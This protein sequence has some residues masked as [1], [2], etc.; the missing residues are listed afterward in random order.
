M[1][2]DELKNWI[3]HNILKDEINHLFRYFAALSVTQLKDYPENLNE[4]IKDYK[5]DW[6]KLILAG[7]VFAQ[8]TDEISND[9]ALLIAHSGLLYSNKKI[10]QKAA[11]EILSQ[12]QNQRTIQ[13]WN[14]LHIKNKKQIETIGTLSALASFK[15]KMS[16]E[17]ITENNFIIHANVFQKKLWE[18]LKNAQ[19]V[20]VSAPTASGKTFIILHWILSL[21]KSKKSNLMVYL[22]PTRA[23]VGEIERQFLTYSKAYHLPEL[24]ISSLP[25]SKFGNGTCPTILVLTQERLHVFLNATGSDV[26]IDQLVVDEAHKVSERQRGIVLQEAIEKINRLSSC[27]RIIQLTPLTDNPEILFSLNQ[28]DEKPHLVVEDNLMI[29]QNLIFMNNIFGK[30]LKKQ[31]SMKKDGVEY[32]LGKIDVEHMFVNK[33]KTIFSAAFEIGKKTTGTLVYA[34]GP[35]VAEKIAILL[36]DAININVVQDEVLTEFSKFI[37]STIHP[38]YALKV[39]VLKGVGFHYGNMPTLL[40]TELER[41]FRD[42]KLKFLVCTSTLVEGVNLAA[43]SIVT[44][45]PKKGSNK[46]MEGHDFWNLAGRA[47]RWGKDFFGNVVCVNTNDKELWNGGVPERKKYTIEKA[48]TNIYKTY[49]KEFIIF[50]EKRINKSIIEPK[51]IH[52]EYLLSYLLNKKL[53]GEQVD[54]N[55]KESQYFEEISKLIEKINSEILNIDSVLA[56]KHPGV[57]AFALQNLY[58]YFNNYSDHISN[59]IP[60]DLMDYKSSIKRYQILFETINEYVFPIFTPQL[61]YPYA[62]TTSRWMHGWPLNKIIVANFNY[63]KSEWYN[64]KPV[65]NAVVIRNT[66]SN[67]EEIC[68]FK[69]PKY[70][71]AY[72]DVLKLFLNNCNKIELFP[73]NLKLDLYLEFGVNTITLLSLIGAGLSRTSALLLSEFLANDNLTEEEIFIRLSKREWEGWELSSIVTKEISELI[74]LR[75]H[76]TT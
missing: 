18:T 68:R 59:L 10:V 17:I 61:L 56:A 64:G 9:L 32:L 8:C 15:N 72:L 13:L 71:S 48:T 26:K 57:S 42:G 35:S 63:Q 12:A 66:M 27:N 50:L 7:S 5:P 75:S 38:T 40:R 14:L 34:N 65:S 6:K 24:R 51:N 54:I 47:G 44:M 31:I 73:K 39:V 21:F 52:F 36:A 49:S 60:N 11:I 76:L 22:A 19:K 69:A 62:L 4:D 2:R 74:D 28:V 29:T 37:E 46:P 1:T 41:L 33:A 45:A 67:V 30:P 23:L 3:I 70:L 20:G 53:F 43:K 25:L 55:I 16:S 58:T